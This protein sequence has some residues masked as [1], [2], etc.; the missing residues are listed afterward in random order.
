MVCDEDLT[1]LRVCLVDD[2]WATGITLEQCAQALK[3]AGAKWPAGIVALA[4]TED[5]RSRPK[6]EKRRASTG[7]VWLERRGGVQKSHQ[8]A[9]SHGFPALGASIPF[10]ANAKAGERHQAIR[11]TEVGMNC[12]SGKANHGELSRPADRGRADPIST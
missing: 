2:L 9:R 6:Q 1:G 5:T 3:E 10:E 7:N 4:V 12:R 8:Q 11:L